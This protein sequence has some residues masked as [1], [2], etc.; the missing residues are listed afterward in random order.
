[1]KRRTEEQ[2]LKDMV[3][4]HQ[5]LGKAAT[6]LRGSALA[7]PTVL[8]YHGKILYH[9]AELAE[10]S[11]FKIESLTKTLVKCTVAL[12]VMTG[13]LVVLTIVLAVFTWKLIQH[14]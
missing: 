1:M 6:T 2:I 13:V 8:E 9:A 14:G 10:V 12:V 11:S 7:V 4:N 3:D 5:E